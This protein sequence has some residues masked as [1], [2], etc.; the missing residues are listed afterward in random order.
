MTPRPAVSWPHLGPQGARPGAPVIGGWAAPEAAVDAREP[1]AHT[2][3]FH[4]RDTGCSFSSPTCGSKQSA[5]VRMQCGAPGLRAAGGLHGPGGV[6]TVLGGTLDPG[7]IGRCEERGQERTGGVGEAESPAVGIGGQGVGAGQKNCNRPEV[8]LCRGQAWLCPT[9]TPPCQ[10]G[11]P[12]LRPEPRAHARPMPR[13]P[14]PQAAP[15]KVR[16]Q[17]APLSE[18]LMSQPQ[19][20]SR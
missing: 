5:A 20:A 10:P 4:T 13:L 7:L 12:A 18:P 2:S 17:N 9:H 3:T 8:S 19:T 6:E 1:G 15:H 11:L 14:P 16:N